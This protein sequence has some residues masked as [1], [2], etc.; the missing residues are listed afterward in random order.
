MIFPFSFRLRFP[1]KLK[2]R[3]IFLSIFFKIPRAR[4]FLKEVGKFFG[5]ENS[6][7]PNAEAGRKLN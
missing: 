6:A 5:F 2:I 1:A 3:K 7:L 4:F